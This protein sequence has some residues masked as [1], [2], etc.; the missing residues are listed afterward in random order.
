MNKK[1]QVFISSTFTDMKAERQAAVEA[2][3]DAGHIPAGMELFSASDKKQIEVIKGWIDRSDIFMLV[4]GGRYGSVD[5]DSGKSYIQLEY[6]HAVETGKPF[7]ALYLT[8]RAVRDKAAGPLGLDAI[9]QNDTKA[10][11]AFRDLVKSKLCSEIDD[12]KDIRI[13]VPKSIRDLSENRNLEGWVRASSVPDLTPLLNELQALR[14]ENSL[15][16]QDATKKASRAPV[17]PAPSHRFDEHALDARLTIGATYPYFDDYAMETRLERT[18]W[19]GTYRAMFSLLG[20]KLLDKPSDSAVHLYL[21]GI[22]SR[23]LGAQ[24]GATTNEDDFQRM[25][26]KFVNLGVTEL[27]PS[28]HA[29]CWTLTDAGKELLLKLHESK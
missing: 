18:Q 1:Y 16:T 24:Q 17:L 4:L 27:T 29:L 22:V 25:K 28:E 14:G 21:N 10:L 23:A 2:I 15:L 5:P 13:Q 19:Q 3:L 12:V 8:D 9:E 26:I 7:F 6:E 11:K 20:A